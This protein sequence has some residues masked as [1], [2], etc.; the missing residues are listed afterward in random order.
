MN[1]CLCVCVCVCVCMHMHILILAWTVAN[2]CVKQRNEKSNY[3]LHNDHSISDLIIAKV[4]LHGYH[5]V[6]NC[7]FFIDTLFN[8]WPTVIVFRKHTHWSYLYVFFWTCSSCYCIL[9]CWLLWLSKYW[10]V[11]SLWILTKKYPF[12]F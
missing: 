7:N 2:A 10:G 3:V 5:L 8:T 12:I 11:W 4:I 6:Q 1:F 9:I